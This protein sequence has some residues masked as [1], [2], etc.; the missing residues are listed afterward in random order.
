MAQPG[1]LLPVMQNWSCHNCGGCC[2]EHQIVITD[3]EKRRIE[4]QR[5]TGQ[6]G[7]PTDRPL[8][9]RHGTA[10]RLNHRDDGACVF[11]NEQ[12]LCRIHARFG[13]PAKPL[14]CRTY[15]YA[16]HPAGPNVTVSLRFSCPS[17][18]QNVGRAVTEQRSSLE[19]LAAEIVPAGYRPG[20][21]PALAEKRRLTDWSQFQLITS[22]LQ[23]G[24]G[25]SSVAFSIRL[26]R[27][28]TW[29]SLLENAPSDSLAPA[30]LGTLLK[31][32]HDASVRAVS[33]DAGPSV[34]PSRL[35]RLM[36][37]QFVAQMLRHDTDATSRG[38]MLNRVSLL[39]QG[40]KFTAGFG[41]VPLPT[42]PPSVAVAFGEPAAGT[43]NT[44]FSPSRRARFRDIERSHG[45]RATDIDELLTRYVQV[46]LEGHHYCGAAFY[47]YSLTDGFR[48]LALMIAAIH[49]VARSRARRAGR[50][51][52]TLRDV[53]ASLTTLDHNSGYSP[54]LGMR[55][56][57]SRIRQ[58]HKLEQLIPLANW[59]SS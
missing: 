13:E 44:H 52:V 8:I 9:A 39:W 36:L 33:L 29:L 27:T 43:D 11:L 15:P 18:T 25:D 26:E 23:R 5:W 34:R 53:Q 30:H 10:W 59:Y 4:A 37:R 58:L 6:D 41:S 49:W 38:G 55:S 14:A 32:L 48:T 47:D 35:S 16:V 22:W 46:K 3:D 2:R 40:L 1:V 20:R 19:Q 42:D 12:G 56:S 57:L 28:L 54:V 50:T 21:P 24:M 7:T 17:V 45:G 31:L 51:T